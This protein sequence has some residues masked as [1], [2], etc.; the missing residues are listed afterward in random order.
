MHESELQRRMSFKQRAIWPFETEFLYLVVR[1]AAI[2]LW[3][4]LPGLSERAVHSKASVSTRRLCCLSHFEGIGRKEDER[5]LLGLDFSA[6][7][8]S[9]A[10]HSSY[11]RNLGELA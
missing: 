7:T 9:I 4:S 3:G 10:V 5:A 1:G 6:E 8:N 2:A 11:P